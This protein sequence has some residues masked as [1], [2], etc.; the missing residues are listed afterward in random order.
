[1]ALN[2]KLPDIGEGITEAEIVN[3]IAA[4]GDEVEEY[5]SVV[6]VMTDKAVVEIPAPCAGTLTEVR[7]AAG[8]TVAVGSVL[9]VIEAKGDAPQ[10]DAGKP[11]PETA[12]GAVST[13][14]AA[15]ASETPTALPPRRTG[16]VLAVPSARHA[17]R[18]LKVD[19]Q[20]VRGTGRNGIIRVADVKAHA[21]AP[22]SSP[23]SMSPTTTTPGEGQSRKPFRGMRR[24]IAEAMSRSKQ[25]AAH[26]TVVEEVDVTELV[27]LRDTAKKLGEKH[28][29]KI[30]YT[31]FF[32]KATAIA[33][34][35]YPELN[36]QLD[37]VTQEIVTFDHVN[38][39][40]AT[41]TPNGL[42][43]PV[44][45]GVQ[46]QGILQLAGTLQELAERTRE[47]KVRPEELRGG[48]FTITNAGPIGGI[49]ATPIINVPEVA[50][51]GIHRIV[52]RPAVV[53]G[54]DGDRVEVRRMMNISLSVDHRIVDGA[55][56]AR[57]L[58]T[59]KEML[60]HPGLL[61]L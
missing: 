40:I 21:A 33:L 7:G 5:Q 57:F 13:P 61:A 10:D 9:F 41:D 46:A 32:M 19:L 49:L 59:I 16:K 18:E 52:K 30:T 51:L 36:S 53:E 42:V 26:F 22:A 58:M 45:P 14:E 60:E 15:V 44:V 29:V 2:F 4:V 24:K 31:P 43:V 38:L 25:T 39:G 17:A 11:D 34:G 35:H 48:T 1:M 23:A 56:A 50:I 3:W 6:E 27:A 54:P 12:P 55:T 8:E 28:G 20:E 37:E 47:G